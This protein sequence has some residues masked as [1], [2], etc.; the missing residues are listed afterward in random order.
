LLQDVG[1]F[2]LIYFIILT[3]ASAL[4]MVAVYTYIRG[5]FLPWF[6]LMFFVVL[7]QVAILFKIVTKAYCQY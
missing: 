2:V 4:L 5:F 3:G 1:I 7:F 6:Y